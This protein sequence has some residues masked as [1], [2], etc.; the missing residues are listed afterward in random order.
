MSL[1]DR[2][3]KNKTIGVKLM[4][5]KT[6]E[7]KN[8]DPNYDPWLNVELAAGYA[9]VVKDVVTHTALTVG[10]V[11]AACKIIGRICK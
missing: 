9:E 10:G 11:W 4:D 5:D 1:S 8:V 2:L 6:S 7:T 3:L